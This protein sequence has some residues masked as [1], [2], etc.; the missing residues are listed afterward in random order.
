MRILFLTF[1]LNPHNNVGAIRALKFIKYLEKMGHEL[2]V[3]SSENA[4]IDCKR[5]NVK[6]SIKRGGTTFYKGVSSKSV[7]IKLFNRVRILIK[8][9]L[10]SP[11]KYIWWNIAFLPQMIKTIKKQKIDIAFATGSPFS[12][13][14][15]L[16]L[17]KTFCSV[18]I[19]LDF[20][21]PWMNSITQEKQSFFRK[22][23][24]KFWE[25]NC[26]V[27]ANGIVAV[28]DEIAYQL[29]EYKPNGVIVSISNGFDPDD[30][31]NSEEILPK[32]NFTFLYTGKYSIHRED[33]NPTSVFNAFKIFKTQ[34]PN[35]S[36]LKFVGPTDRDTL[37]FA[38]KYREFGIF[39]EKAKP[40]NAIFSLQKQSDV[41]I[42]F[43]YPQ[44]YQ[45]AISMKIYEYAYLKKIILCFN[46]KKGI[47]YDFLEKY[48]FGFT[49]SNHDLNEMS[50]LF[51]KAFFNKLE[52]SPKKDLLELEE[53]NYKNLTRRLDDL[54]KLIVKLK[55]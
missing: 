43:Q 22:I 46:I 2:F 26:V 51:Y 24:I 7:F 52:Y 8:D 23:M 50:S 10:F 55:D 29:K 35:D 37:E 54:F 17:L 27:S 48:G 16:Y 19:V 12:T 14:I 31:L 11:D 6:K 44:S 25:K 30:F 40:K 1:Y 36:I 41:F 13:F 3:F 15:S 21:D 39:C 53:Y 49:V 33:Y 38:E 9:I 20:R 5:V 18:P 45:N 28:N 4:H 42:Q 47:L 32:G 34:Y